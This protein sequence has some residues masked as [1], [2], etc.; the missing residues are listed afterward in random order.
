MD[1]VYEGF[2]DKL[3]YLLIVYAISEKLRQ[4][5]RGKN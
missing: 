1:A 4:L 3:R 2:H 5:I